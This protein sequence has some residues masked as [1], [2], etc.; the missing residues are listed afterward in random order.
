[1]VKD[2]AALIPAAAVVLA[3]AVA[4]KL[5]CKHQQ[6]LKKAIESANRDV[7]GRCLQ[8]IPGTCSLAELPSPP[9]L[10][11]LGHNVALVRHGPNKLPELF[12]QWSE[13]YGDA[14]TITL[15][16]VWLVLSDPKDIK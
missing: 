12:Q 3:I 9:A 7:S 6:K 14:F 2:A 5:F 1:M 15:D 16:S 13:Q 11:L 8:N 4:T 10:P